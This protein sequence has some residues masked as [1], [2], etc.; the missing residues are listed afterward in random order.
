[1][2]FITTMPI[3]SG[4]RMDEGVLCKYEQF[5]KQYG[6]IF[7]KSTYSAY[8]LHVEQSLCGKG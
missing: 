1:M 8:L 2:S 6:L 3:P 5:D 7:F 4:K